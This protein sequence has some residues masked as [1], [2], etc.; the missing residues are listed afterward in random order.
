MPKP[1]RTFDYV[2]GQRTGYLDGHKGTWFSINGKL[3]PHVPMFMAN[4]GDDVRVK[5]VNRTSIDHPMHLH[6]QHMLVLSRNGV[7]S[8]GAPWWVDRMVMRQPVKR[9]LKT[10]IL[11]ACAPAC[12]FEMLSVYKSERLD[13]ARIERFSARV[14]RTLAKWS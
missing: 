13:G 10:A 5:F 4:K 9:V 2:I 14:E 11:G 12:N 8:S 1:D 7:K 3:I 6:G